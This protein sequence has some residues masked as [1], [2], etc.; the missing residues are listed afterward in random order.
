MPTPNLTS[1]WFSNCKSLKEL[2]NQIYTLISLQSMFINN[3]PELVSLSEG[4]LPS[5][6]C[7]LSITFCDKIMLGMEWG[8]HRL[9]RLS[10][11]EIDGGCKNVES[12]PEDQLLPSNL[13]S[14]RISRLS[15]LKNVNC[16]Q[17]HHLTALKKLE[18]SSCN[19]LQTLPE[20][21]LPSSL[22]FLCIKECPLLK[23]KLQNKRKR[24]V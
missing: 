1:I 18:I 9:N 14:L 12:F 11:L 5:N 3:C 24:L 13:D 23:P 6:L 22:S 8:L 2:P 19:E 7:L 10:Q 16:R 21:D 17:L 4:R 20:E 15:N